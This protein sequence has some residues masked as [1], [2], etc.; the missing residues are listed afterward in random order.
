MRFKKII[1]LIVAGLIMCS[2]ALAGC[3]AANSNGN[4]NGGNNNGVNITENQNGNNNSVNNTD[5][6][7]T[8]VGI[9]K[10][11]IYTW[12]DTNKTD[13]PSLEKCKKIKAGMSLNQVISEIGKPQRDIGYGACLFQFDLD[14]GSVLTVTFDKDLNKIKN[15]PNISDY[16][17]LIV[18]CMDFEREIPD[19][20]FPY[21]GS[22]SNFYSWINE[23]NVEDIVQVRY[24]PAFI[25]VAPGSFK[26][27]SYTTNSV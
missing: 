19:I 24:E 27:I 13:L 15:N 5:D 26:D 1:G 9:D 7:I 11:N 18:A 22:L 2:I 23:L 4:N 14:D 20:F 16:D 25:G 21:C 17:S 10:Q 8:V 3:D 12:F 6:D